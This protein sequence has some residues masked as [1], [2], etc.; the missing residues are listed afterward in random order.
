MGVGSI[1]DAFHE[2]RGL[3]SEFFKTDPVKEGEQLDELERLIR[4]DPS[5]SDRDPQIR[6]RLWDLVKYLYENP[7][8]SNMV[9]VI[10]PQ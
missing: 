1:L 9:G 6:K 4:G 8:S 2:A 10:T 5:P 3:V 7:G